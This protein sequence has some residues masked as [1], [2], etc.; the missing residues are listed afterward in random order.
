MSNRKLPKQDILSCSIS[1]TTECTV[2]GK[3]YSRNTYVVCFGDNIAYEVTRDEL[4]RLTPSNIKVSLDGKFIC[5][6]GKLPDMSNMFK[7]SRIKFK[8]TMEEFQQSSLGI[9]KKFHALYGNRCCVVKFSKFN[10]QELDNEVV[11]KEVCD[12]LKVLCCDVVKTTYFARPC[13]VSIYE[14]K[15]GEDIFQSFKQLGGS[16]PDIYNKLSVSDKQMFDRYMIVDYILA[17]QDRHMSNLATIN[18]KLYPLYDNGECL[19][20]GSIGQYSNSFIRYVS[21]L[22]KVYIQDILGFSREKLLGVISLVPNSQRLSVKK[23]IEVLFDD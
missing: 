4:S 19:G 16:V 7:D 3:V 21:T 8:S 23:R 2:I 15:V 18:G 5:V 17:Q 22:S 13:I 9:S 20:L 6:D 11:Y 10:L 12:Y 14:Y 1:R